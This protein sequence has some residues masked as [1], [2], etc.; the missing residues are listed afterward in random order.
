MSKLLI[1]IIG[2]LVI[3]SCTYSINM[4]HTEGEATDLINDADTNT[5]TAT[6]TI[7]AKVV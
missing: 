3:S 2:L 1:M 4:A 5:P 7:P 6:A